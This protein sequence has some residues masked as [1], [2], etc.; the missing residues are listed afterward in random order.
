MKHRKARAPIVAVAAMAVALV[1]GASAAWSAST[2]TVHRGAETTVVR[3]G[4]GGLDVGRGEPLTART[5]KPDL[6]AG[7]SDRVTGQHDKA[8][9]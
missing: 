6:S 4:D 2:V 1:A 3:L 7:L 9:E 5:P 8:A